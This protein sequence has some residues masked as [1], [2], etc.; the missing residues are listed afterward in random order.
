MLAMTF[1][2]EGVTFNFSRLTPLPMCF[3]ND[4]FLLSEN[5]RSPPPM[6]TPN[7]SALS[8][9][10]TAFEFFDVATKIALIQ[11]ALASDAASTFSAPN[12]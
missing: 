6:D 8:F 3:S 11:R 1:P 10:L 9:F 7:V 12:P 2:A 5:R 4:S